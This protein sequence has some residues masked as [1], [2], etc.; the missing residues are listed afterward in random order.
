M[1]SISIAAQD[2]IIN[3]VLALIGLA[4]AY[5]VYGIRQ[6][7]AK[8][9]AQTAQIADERA[10]TRLESALDDVENFAYTTVAALEQTVAAGLREEIKS[11]KADREALLRLAEKARQ[12]ISAFI[13]PE[14]KKIIVEH[15]GSFDKYLENVIEE[16]V[17]EVKAM[18]ER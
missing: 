10:K 16:K 17:L 14:A 15:F 9:K 11:G 8:A 12:E 13:R 1:E 3:V 6:L 2:L 7:A 4:S 18:C 5:A